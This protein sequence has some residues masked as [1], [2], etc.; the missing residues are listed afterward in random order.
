MAAIIKKRSL[1]FI[2]SVL[3][4]L[5]SCPLLSDAEALQQ[6]HRK[7]KLS[8]YQGAWFAIVY[9]PG[10]TLKPS[11]RSTTT[12]TG[13]DSAFFISPDK[14][15]AFY[16]FSPQWNGDPTDIVA[17]KEKETV[18]SQKE[19]VK[20]SVHTRWVTIQAR[21]RSYTR[22]FVDIEDTELNVRHVLGWKYR[23][24]KARQKYESAYIRFKA[25]LEQYA[26]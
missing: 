1:W 4:I 18:I 21:D 22:S 25:S 16:V 12:D 24:L 17:D 6:T 20:K 14:T 19:T 7:R 10:F 2:C 11:L 13:Y 26:D 3:V 5:T 15:V 9:P 8:L 23:D